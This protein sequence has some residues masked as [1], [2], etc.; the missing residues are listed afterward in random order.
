MINIRSKVTYQ[1][2]VRISALLGNGEKRLL[3]Y[4]SLDLVEDMR[5]FVPGKTCASSF[6]H[7]RGPSVLQG[8]TVLQEDSWQSPR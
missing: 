3:R 2:R 4:L 7:C 8:T 5:A 1:M 6:P